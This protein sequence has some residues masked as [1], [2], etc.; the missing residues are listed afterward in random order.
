MTVPDTMTMKEPATLE[1]MFMGDGFEGDGTFRFAEPEKIPDTYESTQQII[2]TPNDT[3]TYDYSGIQ[4]W[5]QEG[6]Q[7]IRSVKVYVESLKT[8]EP[9][10]EDKEEPKKDESATED[11]KKDTGSGDTG[12]SE[13]AEN[14]NGSDKNTDTDKKDTDK[15]EKPADDKKDPDKT[16][17]PTDDKK[18]AEDKKDDTS[19]KRRAE[20]RR[21]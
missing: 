3:E 9:S 13:T 14:P 2:F 18:D 7:V 4:G 8:P 11:P 21:L 15:T 16:E 5:S 12:K 1:S 19:K 17:K 6:Q 10:A 20:K